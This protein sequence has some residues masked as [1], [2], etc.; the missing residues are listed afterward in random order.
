MPRKS[1]ET[2]AMG[3]MGVVQTGILSFYAV[4]GAVEIGCFDSNFRYEVAIN[5]GGESRGIALSRAWEECPMDESRD[6][7]FMHFEKV[8]WQAPFKRKEEAMVKF[9]D[10]SQVLTYAAQLLCKV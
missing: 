5:V 8:G 6:G 2:S 3:K 10:H 4:E 7:G 9:R 1:G